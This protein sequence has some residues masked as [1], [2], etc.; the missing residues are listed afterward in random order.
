MNLYVA[1]DSKTLGQAA[2]SAIAGKLNDAIAQKGYARLLLSTGQSQFEVLEA[3]V[4]ENVEWRKVM[5]FHLDEY[6]NLPETHVASFRKYL[7]ERFTNKVELKEAFFVEVDD[8]V[9]GHIA[10][11]SKRVRELPVDVGVI[12]IGENAHIAFNDP[13]ADFDTREAYKIVDLDVACRNQQVH[14]GWFSGIDE[15]PK[16]A[17]SMTPYQIMQCECIISCVP[18]AVKKQAIAQ[19]LSASETTPFIPATL[20]KT[21]KD[22]N[23]FVDRDSASGCSDALLASYN[24]KYL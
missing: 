2:A 5:M 18:R 20:L 17:V 12:G 11:L 22:F 6:V 14:E 24:A 16:Q 21:H 9:E 10:A 4:Q 7:K 23:L 13:P 19:T 8:D 15:V 1:Q 3:L